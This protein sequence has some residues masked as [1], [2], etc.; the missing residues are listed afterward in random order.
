MGPASSWRIDYLASVR[1]VHVDST[2]VRAQLRFAVLAFGLAL[3]V[4][5]C[6]G[7]T[8]GDPQP[9]PTQVVQTTAI[10]STTSPIPATVLSPDPDPDPDPALAPAPSP[11]P[12]PTPTPAATE[13]IGPSS[14]DVRWSNGDVFVGGTLTIP[15][16]DPL[17]LPAPAVLLIADGGGADRDWVSEAIPGING[18]GRMIANE[19]TDAGY[20]TL[21]YD[22]RG[23]GRR[24]GVTRPSDGENFLK[25]SV[26]EVSSAIKYLRSRPEVDRA[27]I[28]SVAHDEGALHALLR[29]SQSTQSDISGM[30]LLAPS[31]LTLKQQVFRKLGVF[32]EGPGDERLLASFDAAMALFIEGTPPEGDLRLSPDLQALFENL[33]YPSNQPYNSEIW[34]LE[35][36][37]LLQG[38][39]GPVLVLIGQLD[40]DVDWAE[41]GQIWRGAAGSG[42]DLE[43]VQPL[44]TDHVL[45]A[46]LPDASETGFITYNA[47]G[48]T[49]DDESMTSLL[50]W[51]N[52]LSGL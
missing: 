22:R 2:G 40:T 21:R 38:F 24:T 51:L 44:N 30:A 19:L 5:A 41:E 33:T 37:P 42:Q 45:M 3:T 18:S 27:R 14:T 9:V 28:F 48:R 1:F 32:A 29:E 20:I 11:T 8:G 34:N 4:T 15:A 25:D 17:D 23:T 16:G 13:S 39:S 26:D 43:L 50:D 47:F 7:P 35:V 12:A 6:S 52:S 36:T 49:L 10:A 46:T 31:A